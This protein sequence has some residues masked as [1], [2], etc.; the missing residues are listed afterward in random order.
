MSGRDAREGEVWKDALP[1]LIEVATARKPPTRPRSRGE[2]VRAPGSSRTFYANK[3]DRLG[4]EFQV[5]RMAFVGLQTM[6]PRIVRIPPGKCNER[7][8]H[9]HESL[10]VVLKGSAEVLIGE[11][12]YPT[13]VGEVAFVPRWIMHQTRN[14]GDEEL[15]LLAITDFGFTNALLGN[16]D[17][18]TRLSD[19]GDDADEGKE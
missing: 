9:A 4:I 18:R 7:H 1:R 16:Y 5:E 3:I 12:S 17:R 8:R 15:V 11:T 2:C 19:G 6:D 13:A 10:F 14:V